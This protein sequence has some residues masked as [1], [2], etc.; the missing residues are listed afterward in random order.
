VSHLIQVDNGG[1]QFRQKARHGAFT[2]ADAPV[3][4]ITFIFV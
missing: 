1:A 2:A 4:P 3:S